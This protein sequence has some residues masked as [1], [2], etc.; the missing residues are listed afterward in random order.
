MEFAFHPLVRREKPRTQ[1]ALPPSSTPHLS[2][3]YEVPVLLWTFYY[4][5]AITFVKKYIT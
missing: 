1:T 4:S 2:E 3:G 5:K